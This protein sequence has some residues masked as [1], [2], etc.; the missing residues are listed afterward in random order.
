MTTPRGLT[1]GLIL[2]LG[3]LM[4]INPLAA[5]MYLPGLGDLVADLGTSVAGGQL[6]YTAFLV[7][8]AGGQ[9][10]VGM[11]SDVRGRRPVIRGGLAVLCIA[12]VVAALANSIEVLLAARAVQGL[13]AAAVIV[14]ARAVVSDSA[15]GRAAARAYS[16]LMGLLAAGPFVAPL[17][18][19]LALTVG[20]WRAGFVVLAVLS[21]AALVAAWAMV[22]ETLTRA[23][24]TAGGARAMAGNYLRLV[25]DRA[26]LG[27]VLAMAFGFAA[28]AV[29]S[30]AS[31]FIVQEVLGLSP[32][33][34]A[35]IYTVHAGAVLLGSMGNAFL[36]GRVGARRMMVVAQS[37]AMV[38]AALLLVIAVW[39][40]FTVW[41]FVPVVF[42]GGAA[43]SAILANASALTLARAG[44]AAASGAALMGATQYAI[45]AAAAPIGGLLGPHTAVPMAAGMLG[46]LVLSGISARVGARAD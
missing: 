27:N 29:H 40:P 15:T 24:R 26:Y 8:V 20:G 42:V 14:V 31:P 32:W 10:M 16:L 37:V 5:T 34:F 44:F 13:G 17:L 6:V 46:C 39:G 4:T 45:A 25:R 38:A 23:R 22:P 36:A 11:L 18:G 35:A 30:A 21:A 1:P 9:L 28:F 19:T 33:G 12:S 43:T 2:V 41:T 7:G 3:A